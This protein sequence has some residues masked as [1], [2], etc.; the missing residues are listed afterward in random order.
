MDLNRLEQI[1]LN[2]PEK[3]DIHQ[4]ISIPIHLFH[5]LNE[6]EGSEKNGING[7]E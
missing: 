6:I 1:N 3:I 5:E 2:R 4:S 7:L